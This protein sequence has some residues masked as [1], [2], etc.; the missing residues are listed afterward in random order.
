MRERRANPGL[1]VGDGRGLRTEA[2]VDVH[3]LELV[4]RLEHPVVAQRVLPENVDRAGDVSP[5]LRSDLGAG[6]LAVAAHIE[7]PRIASPYCRL[8]LV[9]G[10]DDAVTRSRRERGRFDR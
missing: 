9:R 10:R 7:E 8:D 3:L 1:A 4:C 5:V 6:V 2:R